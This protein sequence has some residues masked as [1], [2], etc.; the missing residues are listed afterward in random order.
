MKSKTKELIKNSC[1]LNVPAT[2]EVSE[3]KKWTCSK[4]SIVEDLKNKSHA[5]AA[6]TAARTF[7]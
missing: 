1:I 4:L 2:E 6:D 7:Y 3:C 5:A